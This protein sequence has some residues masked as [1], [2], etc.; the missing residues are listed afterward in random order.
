MNLPARFSGARGP[1]R[2]IAI[3]L[4]LGAAGFGLNMLELQLGWG[5]HFVFGNAL[6]FA[7]LRVLRP[8]TLVAAVSISSLRSVLL[9]HH[10]WAW[11]VWTIEAAILALCGRQVSPIRVDVV[12]WLLVG[13][14]LLIATYGGIMGMDSLS[15]WLVI[16]K[17][18]TNGILNMALGEN[19][20]AIIIAFFTGTRATRFPR[21]PIEAFVVMIF[22]SIVLIPT[23]VYLA[24]DA[25][26]REGDARAAVARSLND[27]LE[28]TST[29]LQ[30]WQESRGLM[31]ES[32]ADQRDSAGTPPLPA[33]LQDE[34]DQIA[35]FDA[36]GKLAWTAGSDAA[37]APLRFAQ[38]IG[39]GVGAR[40]IELPGSHRLALV[41]PHQADRGRATLIAR[42]RPATLEK[43]IRQ[44]GRRDLDELL[45]SSPLLD[46]Q[47]LYSIS[48]F[49]SDRLNNLSTELRQRALQRPVLISRSGYGNALMSDLRDA[50]MVRA[51]PV[52][53][54]PGWTVIGVAHLS[55]SVL[56]AREGQLQLFGALSAFVVVI[57]LVG[58]LL[59]RKI[60]T[61]LRELAQSAADLAMA[62]TRSDKL[63]SLVI[64][65]L[66]AISINIATV[67]SQVARERGALVSYQRRLRSIARHAPVVVY[68]LDV[69]DRHKGALVY[70]SEAI[71][72]LLGYTADDAARP[73]WWSH[74][75]HPDD[76]DHCL[77]AFADLRP[78]K[79]VSLEYRLRH[80]QG[81]YVWVYDNLA[82]ETDPIL[83]RSEAVGLLID[84]SDRKL[85]AEQLLQ[86]DKM[87][88]LGR[89]VA[90]VAHELNQP[91][92]FIKMAASNLRESTNRGLFD[93]GRFNAKLDN[94]I[95]HVGRASAIIL[96]MRVFG[97]K[98][99]DAPPPHAS[100]TG[101]R[102]RAG[103]GDAPVRGRRHPHRNRPCPRRCHGAGAAG[104]A[105]TG[106]AQPDA[107]RQ[108][109]DPL[110]PG[111]RQQGARPHRHQG[112]AA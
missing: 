88:S 93:A 79:S 90:G 37:R 22:T 92:N 101:G 107:Q 60:K 84:I 33:T 80:K 54:L 53:S 50:L 71:E 106:T 76:Y 38:T 15:L 3:A 105:R 31:V 52:A 19:I 36:A 94:I 65:E 82:V 35:E 2:E 41:V 69:Q 81:H 43:R 29:A 42:L 30:V 62:G 83:G 73:G 21:M 59:A 68:A 12:F 75:I 72:T 7:F 110:P 66:S 87:A 98:P 46:A 109:R 61:S 48:P 70:V 39:P 112:G 28:V 44:L 6:A 5:M 34:F 17:Q 58:S 91:L 13:T 25:P 100:Q 78:G 111:C 89:M 18:A 47:S 74:A 8:A 23:T 16:A 77:A 95:A 108:G 56:K 86:A 49:K 27:G 102:C 96:Q 9:W 104:A 64:S 67:G 32:F 57:T 45:L 63:D 14:P 24:L 99:T 97:R 40:L 4:V 20:Y 55:G 10:P 103:H 85:A 11:A 1:L 51:S 26:V